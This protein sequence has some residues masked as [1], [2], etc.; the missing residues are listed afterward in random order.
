MERLLMSALDAAAL[1]PLTMGQILDRAVRLYRRNFATFT[2]IVALMLVPLSIIQ[3]VA[4][5]INV[6]ATIEA[7]EQL[8]ELSGST[9]N[10]FLE[11]AQL[12]STSTGG[13]ITYVV[14]LLTFVLVNGLAT[15]A[16]A[17]AVGNSYLGEKTGIFEAYGRSLGSW[18]KLLL[19]MFIGGIIASLLFV[20]WLIPC[21]GWL[22][23]GGLLV[24]FAYIIVPLIPTVIVLEGKDSLSAI[25]RAWDLARRRFWWVLGFVIV[26]WLFARVAISG[27]VVLISMVTN[28]LLL[29]FFPL[30][31]QAT[32]IT[33]RT[34]VNQVSTLTLQL[35]YIPLQITAFSLM[36][37][38][39]RVRTEGF[40]LNLMMDEA[41]QPSAAS[42][43]GID[44]PDTSAHIE[45]VIAQSPPAGNDTLVTGNEILYF[46][47]ITVGTIA[48][49]G[50]LYFLLIMLVVLI[51]SA[52]GAGFQG[53]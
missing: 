38:D 31:D 26:L 43:E 39:L 36:Y 52:F 21:V 23:G 32:L 2:G 14:L 19:S 18:M 53:G 11:F 10:P 44:A 50:G 47:G 22:F 1:R 12:I 4:S 5:I 3:L 13:P 8:A 15:A 37:F 27:P 28:L 17:R 45:D 46:G 16:L 49:G 41:Q 9:T 42:V 29:S 20:F 51:F 35:I 48:I 24:Y 6:P 30:E 40:D 33:V 7:S 34:I 25:R